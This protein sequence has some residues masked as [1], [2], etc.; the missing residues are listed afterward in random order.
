MPYYFDYC[1]FVTHFDSLV[2][3][4]PSSFQSLIIFCSLFCFGFMWALHHHEVS[5]KKFIENDRISLSLRIIWGGIDIFLRL[6]F[7]VSPFII[8]ILLFCRS[9]QSSG[10]SFLLGRFLLLL[11]AP[12]CNSLF[13]VINEYFFVTDFCMPSIT[14]AFGNYTL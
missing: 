10:N 6:R 1:R 7:S 4:H 3:S 9:W 2:P 11:L 8:V 5:E 14:F 13:T 12:I